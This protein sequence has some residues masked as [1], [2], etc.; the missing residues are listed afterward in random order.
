ML[1]QTPQ[2]KRLTPPMNHFCGYWYNTE[3]SKILAVHQALH[4]CPALFTL[5]YPFW[6][7]F[8]QVSMLNQCGE[9]SANVGDTNKMEQ[10]AGARVETNVVDNTSGF[11]L[12]LMLTEN[13]DYCHLLVWN[14]TSHRSKADS[15]CLLEGCCV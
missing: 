8:S 1:T 2:F 6:Q 9:R 11:S 7:L 13:T 3:S 14:F 15:V 5:I 4:G 12:W 10:T